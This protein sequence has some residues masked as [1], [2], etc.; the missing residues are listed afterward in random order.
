VNN[1]YQE[2]A[3]DKI[4]V[5]EQSSKGNRLIRKQHIA[6]GVAVCSHLLQMDYRIKYSRD[7]RAAAGR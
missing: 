5:S 6:G 2:Q 7:S 1:Q 4:K 3:R